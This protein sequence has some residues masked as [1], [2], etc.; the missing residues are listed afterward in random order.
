[1]DS[2]HFLSV[3]PWY[4]YNGEL[5]RRIAHPQFVGF[6][7]PE[8]AA[9]RGMRLVI[10]EEGSVEEGNC[11]RFYFLIDPIDGVIADIAFQVYGESALIGAAE[12][13]SELLIRKNY[14]QALRITADLIDL[15]IRGK[16]EK[17]S[18][19]EETYSHLNLVLMAIENACEQCGDIPLA[20]NYAPQTPLQGKKEAEEYPGWETLSN[21]KKLAVIN[22][23]IFDEIQPYIEL[24]EG[25]VKVLELKENDEVIIAYEGA[26]TSCYSSIGGTLSAIQEIL[27]TK[28]HPRLKVT[29][30]MS[31]LTL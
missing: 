2:K 14:D 25:G 3:F 22:Q 30:D 11:I 15:H 28:I 29:P 21:K 18:F 19:P 13:A 27:R 12:V 1:M 23:I 16:K 31:N 7:T 17:L 26:C 10:G 24:D 8:Q 5:K 6:F 20:E 4:Y 9:E